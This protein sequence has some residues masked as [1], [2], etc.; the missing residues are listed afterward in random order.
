M[1]K[2][3][4]L[5]VN[6]PFKPNFLGQLMPSKYF[7]FLNKSNLRGFV[8]MPATWSWVRAKDLNF[9]FS[10]T[11][12]R[13]KWFLLSIYLVVLWNTGI[14]ASAMADLLSIW[15]SINSYRLNWRSFNSLLSQTTWHTLD[16]KPTYSA[17]HYKADFLF[18]NRMKA[19]S[20]M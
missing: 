8:K 10:W 19:V 5:I 9:F 6:I 18:D 15:I 13:M 12:S 4:D 16:D 2:K 20:P 11:C 1:K 7:I 14:F 3:K 17:S